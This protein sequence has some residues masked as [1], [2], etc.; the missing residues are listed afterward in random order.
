MLHPRSRVRRLALVGAGLV[1]CTGFAAGV[2]PAAGAVLAAGGA[3]A[4]V[5]A[6][7][8]ARPFR[9]AESRVNLSELITHGTRV[10]PLRAPGARVT[11]TNA[12][13][14]Q[15]SSATGAYTALAPLRILDTRT[16]GKT[17]G[18]G[19]SLSLTVTGGSVP[20][21]ASAVALNVTVTDTTA[22]SFLTVYPAGDARPLVS[23]LNWVAHET[24]PNL[25]IVAVGAGGQVTFYNDAGSTD[26]VV[27]LQGYFAPEPSGTTTGSYV[28]LTP[29]RIADTR[30]ASGEPY[31]GQTLTTGST[32]NVQVTGRGNVPSTGVAAVLMNVTVTDTTAASYLTVYPQGAA[33]PLASSLNWVAG[34]TVPNRVVVPVGPGG[35]VSFYNDAGNTDLIVDVDGYFTTG[36]STPAGA[37]LFSPMT[38][39]RVLDTR[40]T[41]QPLGAGATLVQDLASVDGIAANASAVVA[42]ITA[43]DTTAASF[44]TVYPGGTRPLA[45]DLNWISGQTVPN[46]TVATLGGT[47]AVDV[48]NDAGQA[49]L[50]IDAYGYFVPES[51]APLAVTTTALPST[52]VGATYAASLGAHG[53]TPPYSWQLTTG[54]LPPGLS[55]SS[56][57]SI[58]GTASTEGSYS[59]QVQATDST[60]PTP[61]TASAQLSILVA[62]A[63]LTVTTTGLPEAYVGVDYSAILTAAGG[64]T[65]YSWTLVSGSLPSGMTLSPAG[66]ISGYTTAEGTS[67]GFEVEV[68]DSSSPT[69]NTATATLSI[70]VA[71]VTGSTV[72]S[73][74]WSGYAM[75]SGPFNYASGSFNVPGLDATPTETFMSEWVGI[76]GATNSD[77]IQAGVDVYY[78]P[79][80]GYMYLSAWWEI[81]PAAETLIS[82]PVV[83]GDSMTVTVGQV[84]GTEWSIEITNNSTGQTFLTDQTYTGPGSSAEWIVEAPEVNGSIATL[85]AYSPDVT[86]TGIRLNGAETTIADIVMVQNN[87]QVST[88]S[89][90]TS[91]GFTVA[92][93]GSAPP[94]P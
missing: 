82:M 57:G 16:D 5:T 93:G 63:P 6:G 62:P 67:S 88:P 54:S 48:Y 25:V 56:G 84:T 45:S 34:E 76:D 71:A 29:A 27:D 50:L 73:S 21:A 44:F 3:V 80:T 30:S 15:G 39:V 1:I 18:P 31:A 90:F 53:G 42:N 58:S 87:A 10:L 75:G 60:T 86:F 83:P 47:G 49:D 32:L 35:Q 46:L 43:T 68:V 14:T 4:P 51:P 69:S 74:N 41:A 8:M 19:D 72:A 9:G 33:Q 61:G 65:P 26:V 64:T 13:Q 78:D 17:L 79:A 24:V 7:T 12:G 11:P 55:L 92:Y 77:L 23:N 38:P 59:F 22:S 2:T 81:L 70:S 20:A 85:A 37:S 91:S 40:Q 66:V 94:P 28:P 52:S 89:A 36:T